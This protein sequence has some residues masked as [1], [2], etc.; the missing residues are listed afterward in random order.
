M[1]QI[2]ISIE[3]RFSEIKEFC[4]EVEG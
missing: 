2:K 4:E 3:E 1:R